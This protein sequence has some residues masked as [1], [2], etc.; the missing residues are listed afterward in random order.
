MI[1]INPAG[2]EGP[3]RR[4]TPSSSGRTD[5]WNIGANSLRLSTVNL[6]AIPER[7]TDRRRIDQLAGF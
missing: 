5:F 4:G 6:L 2:P 1:P 7:E 3:G